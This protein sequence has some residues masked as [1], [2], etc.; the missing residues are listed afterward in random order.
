MIARWYTERRTGISKQSEGG[1]AAHRTAAMTNRSIDSESD[2][3][4]LRAD[5][6][7]TSLPIRPTS[8]SISGD[9]NAS[10]GRKRVTSPSPT[11]EVPALQ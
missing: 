6:D 5:G 10:N 1:P 11:G 3:I 7:S 4:S 9:G 8:I 2:A